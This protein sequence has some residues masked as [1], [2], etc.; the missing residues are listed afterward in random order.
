M[1]GPQ[2]HAPATLHV[3]RAMPLDAFEHG[4]TS[5]WFWADPMDAVIARSLI[6]DLKSLFLTTGNNV[7]AVATI[8]ALLDPGVPSLISARR[9]TWYY[10]EESLPAAP[11]TGD[12]NGLKTDERFRVLRQYTSAGAVEA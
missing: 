3:G 7:K 2:L 9:V 5:G 12:T 8:K 1:N 11:R 10:Y 6:V 4:L